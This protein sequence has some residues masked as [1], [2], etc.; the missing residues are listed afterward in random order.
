MMKNNLFLLALA[1][2]L[3]VSCNKDKGNHLEDD[4]N[5]VQI[6][7]SIDGT[8][9]GGTVSAGRATVDNDGEGT[10]DPGDTWGLY[11][12]TTEGDYMNANT[13]YKYEETILYWKD[14]SETEAVTFSAHYPRI[15]EEI[16]D[17][18]AYIYKPWNHTDDLLHAT[19]TASKGETVALTFKH[20]MHRLVVNLIAG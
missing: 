3:L 20:L 5:V 16:A 19:A 2:L 17:P 11:A 10:F 14:L 4:D 18:A 9:D 15:T 13:E 8:A 1:T 6:T 7:A 12:Y